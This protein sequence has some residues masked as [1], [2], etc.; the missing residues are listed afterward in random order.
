MKPWNSVIQLLAVSGTVSL[1]GVEYATEVASLPPSRNPSNARGNLIVDFASHK[2][3]HT[4]AVESATL[5]AADAQVLELD[6]R[7]IG[8][9]PQPKPLPVLSTCRDGRKRELWL[10]FDFMVLRADGIEIHECKPEAECVRLSQEFPGRY[11]KRDDGAW[12]GPEIET[13]LAQYGF[14]FRIV[15]ESEV[16]PTLLRNYAILAEVTGKEYSNPAARAKILN[17]LDAVADGIALRAL[18]ERTETIGYAKNDIYIAI[19]RRDVFTP[20]ADQLLVDDKTTRVFAKEHHMEAY[21][22]AHLVAK[23]ATATP[24]ILKPNDKVTWNKAPAFTDCMRYL[25]TKRDPR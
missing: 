8:Y 13:A 1:R 15:T 4:C 11:Q 18:L 2:M 14:K 24:I 9:F 22:L 16:P 7:C 20:L 25:R 10:T 3:G 12:G 19:A 5:E 17:Q 23:A 6:D 21:R